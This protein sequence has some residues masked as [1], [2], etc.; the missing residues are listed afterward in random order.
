MTRSLAWDDRVSVI[1]ERA[2]GHRKR[3]DGTWELRDQST[4]SSVLG[5]GGIYTSIRDYRMWDLAL[6]DSRVLGPSAIRQ[7]LTPG[8]LDDGS[9]TGYGFGWRLEEKRGLLVCHHTGSTTGFNA[10]ARR[11]PALGLCTIYLANRNGE[12][13]KN[14]APQIED[15]ALQQLKDLLP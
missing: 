2:F 4:T 1:E 7:A 5:D 10:F 6:S 14:L 15:L 9:S 3:E 12:E 13:P 11:I 8:R